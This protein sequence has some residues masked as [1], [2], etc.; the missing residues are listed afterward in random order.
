MPIDFSSLN[1]GFEDYTGGM[2]SD[3]A[4]EPSSIIDYSDPHSILTSKNWI[5]ASPSQRAASAPIA[6]DKFTQAL[7]SDKSR[8]FKLMDDAGNEDERP[9]FDKSGNYTRDGRDYLERAKTAFDV[10]AQLE[11]GGSGYDSYNKSF[12]VNDTIG[13]ILTQKREKQPDMFPG[14]DEAK[15]ETQAVMVEGKAKDFTF[16]DYVNHRNANLPEDSPARL[17][18]DNERMRKMFDQ[19]KELREFDPSKMDQDAF[20]WTA[21]GRKLP[22]IKKAVSDLAGAHAA[23][24]AEDVS[25][26]DKKMMKIG[27]RDAINKMDSGAITDAANAEANEFT[28]YKGGVLAPVL[29]AVGGEV[30]DL[31]GMEGQDLHSKFQRHMVA[32]GDMYSFIEQNQ[33]MF[34]KDQY[35]MLDKLNNAYWAANRSTGAGAML[36]A[37]A[38]FG[39]NDTITQ[40]AADSSAVSDSAFEGMGGTEHYKA[41]GMNFTNKGMYDMAGQV[42]SVFTSFGSG[43]LVKGG[44]KGL[45]LGTAAGATAR[46]A[47]KSVGAVAGGAAGGYLGSELGEAVGGDTGEMVG[48]IVGGVVGGGLGATGV[49]ALKGTGAAT[50]LGRQIQLSDDAI[51]EAATRLAPNTFKNFGIKALKDPS[52]YVGALQAGGMSFGSTYNDVFEQTGDAEKAYHKAGIQGIS[53]GLAAFVSTAVFNRIA[54]GLEKGMSGV[55]GGWS[56]SI[57]K[58]MA[59]NKAARSA[60]SREAQDAAIE[61]IEGLA[62]KDSPLRAALG[63]ALRE[64]VNRAARA[65]GLKGYGMGVGM[66]TEFFEEATDTALSDVFSAMLDD[67]KTWKGEVWDNIQSK[68]SEY[69]SAGVMGA[70]GGGLGGGL[71]SGVDAFS[72]FS[73]KSREARVAEIKQFSEVVWGDIRRNGETDGVERSFI[74]AE[75]GAGMRAMADYMVDESIPVKTRAKVLAQH[76]MSGFSGRSFTEAVTADP[77][78]PTAAQTPSVAPTPTATAATPPVATGGAATPPPVGTLGDVLNSSGVSAPTGKKWRADV[79]MVPTKGATPLK[80]AS[81]VTITPMS[82]PSGEGRSLATYVA[83]KKETIDP[84]TGVVTVEYISADQAHKELSSFTPAHKDKFKTDSMKRNFSTNANDTTY[85][86]E[87]SEKQDGADTG[88]DAEITPPG[89]KAVV[90]DG[91]P[92]GG[93]DSEATSRGA[94]LKAPVAGPVALGQ[95]VEPSGNPEFDAAFSNERVVFDEKSHTYTIDN[96]I[97]P[98]VTTKIEQHP[99][100]EYDGPKGSDASDVGTAIH[101][102]MEKEF[103]GKP[104]TLPENVVKLLNSVKAMAKGKIVSEKVLF[105]KNFAGTVDALIPLGNGEWALLDLKTSTTIKSAENYGTRYTNKKTGVKK[106][107]TAMKHEL[108]MMAYREALAANGINVTKTFILNMPMDAQEQSALHEIGTSPETKELYNEIFGKAEKRDDFSPAKEAPSA[109]PAAEPAPAAVELVVKEKP[110]TGSSIRTYQNSDGTWNAEQNLPVFQQTEANLSFSSTSTTAGHA[111]EQVARDAAKGNRTEHFSRAVKEAE[112]LASKLEERGN[113]RDIEGARN[114]RNQIAQF[115]KGMSAQ[116]DP[117]ATPAAA[118]AESAPAAEE[119]NPEDFGFPKV[120]KG[121]TVINSSNERP[122]YALVE[123]DGKRYYAAM[124]DSVEEK[125]NNL[126]GQTVYHPDSSY[127]NKGTGGEFFLEEITG[128]D[129][130]EIVNQQTEDSDGTRFTESDTIY[131]GTD[132]TGRIGYYSG[133]GIQLEFGEV[134]LIPYKDSP[135]P[136]TT[137][138]NQTDA[139][140]EADAEAERKGLL[141]EGAAEESTPA[142][143]ESDAEVEPYSVEG[144]RNEFE[145]ASGAPPIKANFKE[146]DGIFVSKDPSKTVHITDEAIQEE[147]DKN[148]GDGEKAMEAIEARIIALGGH[149]NAFALDVQEKTTINA[150]STVYQDVVYVADPELIK[151]G[152]DSIGGNWTMDVSETKEVVYSYR[153]PTGS[154]LSLSIGEVVAIEGKPDEFLQ[155]TNVVNGR[156]E[157]AKKTTAEAAGDVIT[158]KGLINQGNKY[159]RSLLAD[160]AKEVQKHFKSIAKGDITPEN[161]EKLFAKVMKVVSPKK[162]F[163]VVKEEMS[164]DSFLYAEPN[165]D[166]T[167]YGTIKVDYAKM[168]V[169]LAKIYKNANTNDA[170]SNT[171]L[172]MDAARVISAWI[173]EELTHLIGFKIFNPEELLSFYTSILNLPKNKDGSDHEFTK[174]LTET[175]AERYP[176]MN[177]KPTLNRKQKGTVGGLVKAERKQL[178]LTV[179]TELIRKLHQMATKGTT[180][181]RDTALSRQL[182][183]AIYGDA[184]DDANET[185]GSLSKSPLRVIGHMIRRYAERVRNILWMKWQTGTLPPQAREMLASM[186]RAYRNEGIQGDVDYGYDEATKEAERR[187]DVYEKAFKKEVGKI[188]R[189]QSKTAMKLRSISRQFGHMNLSQSLVVDHETMTLDLHP[190]IKAHIAEY[191]TLTDE[192][193]EQVEGFLFDLNDKGGKSPAYQQA[194]TVAFMKQQVME[195]RRDS[196]SFNPLDLFDTIRDDNNPDLSPTQR[197]EANAAKRMLLWRTILDGMPTEGVDVKEVMSPLTKERNELWD[198]MDSEKRALLADVLKQVQDI[199]LAAPGSKS[200]RELLAGGRVVRVHSRGRVAS[201]MTRKGKEDGDGESTG[202]VANGD[203]MSYRERSFER[204]PSEKLFSA[205]ADEFSN[206]L[207]QFKNSILQTLVLSAPYVTSG[208]IDDFLNEKSD[209]IAASV[210]RVRDIESRIAQ[211]DEILNAFRNVDTSR[212]DLSS[213]EKA[214][215]SA[216]K[217]DV[218]ISRGLPKK[219]KRHD[220]VFERVENQDPEARANAQAVYT[221]Y[222]EFQQ[223]VDDYN[224]SIQFVKNRSVGEFWKSSEDFGINLA[225]LNV[226]TGEAGSL[227]FKSLSDTLEHAYGSDDVFKGL[228]AGESVYSYGAKAVWLKAGKT[229]TQEQEDWNAGLEIYQQTMESNADFVGK[230]LFLNYWVSSQL[231]KLE[232]GT[233][234]SDYERTG[235]FLFNKEVNDNDQEEFESLDSAFPDFDGEEFGS[236]KHAL[237]KSDKSGSV[238]AL[239]K[240]YQGINSWTAKIKSKYEGPITDTVGGEQSFAGRMTPMLQGL[241]GKLQETRSSLTGETSL[242]MTGGLDSYLQNEMRVVMNDL[243]QHYKTKSKYNVNGVFQMPSGKVDFM[244]FFELE[245]GNLIKISTMKVADINNKLYNTIVSGQGSQF[246]PWGFRNATRG[247]KLLKKSLKAF[248]NDKW[249]R[250]VEYEG[251]RYQRD[252]AFEPDNKAFLKLKE[253]T[254][255]ARVVNRLAWT[256]KYFE[257]DRNYIYGSTWAYEFYD[258]INRSSYGEGRMPYVKMKPGSD[259]QL[260]STDEVINPNDFSG[261]P[262]DP[263]VANSFMNASSPT[264]EG[265]NDTYNEGRASTPRESAERAFGRPAVNRAMSVTSA[266]MFIGSNGP[267][268]RSSADGQQFHFDVMRAERHAGWFNAEQVIAERERR[269]ALNPTGMRSFGG[270]VTDPSTGL[271]VPRI[272]DNDIREMEDRMNEDLAH[273]E[274]FPYDQKAVNRE[275]FNAF[276]GAMTEELVKRGLKGLFPAVGHTNDE[277]HGQIYTAFL[278]EYGNKL[279]ETNGYRFTDS[280]RFIVELLE[281]KM[282]FEREVV[283]AD[284]FKNQD[285]VAVVY[286]AIKNGNPFVSSEESERITAAIKESMVSENF[287]FKDARLGMGHGTGNAIIDHQIDNLHGR[288]IVAHIQSDVANRHGLHSLGIQIFKGKPAD[289]KTKTPAT[290]HVVI[291]P[292]NQNGPYVSKDKARSLISQLLSISAK[293]DPS[294]KKTLLGVAD[295]I[296]SAL[297]PV[298]AVQGMTMSRRSKPGK[299]EFVPAD[300]HLSSARGKLAAT[301]NNPNKNERTI[302][303]ARALTALDEIA[304]IRADFDI[305]SRSLS[306]PDIDPATADAIITISAFLTDDKAKTFLDESF[307]TREDKLETTLPVQI[308]DDLMKAIWSIRQSKLDDPG[309]FGDET[310]NSTY[311]VEEEPVDSEEDEMDEENAST[312]SP[313][314]MIEI[315]DATERND[316]LSGLFDNTELDEFQREMN[317]IGEEENKARTVMSQADFSQNDRSDNLLYNALSSIVLAGKQFNGVESDAFLDE[318]RTRADGKGRSTNEILRDQGK[319]VYT[320]KNNK[321]LQMLSSPVIKTNSKEDKST[322]PAK[323]LT[324]MQ[325]VARIYVGSA[326]TLTMPNANGRTR[327]TSGFYG[328]RIKRINAGLLYNTGSVEAMVE[329]QMT[330][331][332]KNALLA[333]AAEN[334]THNQ[335]NDSMADMKFGHQEL[336]V[337]VNDQLIADLKVALPRNAME[338]AE[339]EA[340]ALV[341][342]HEDNKARF[343]DVLAGL[344]TTR[345]EAVVLNAENVRKY[346]AGTE[347]ALPDKNGKRNGKKLSVDVMSNAMSKENAE[348]AKAESVV[349]AGKL[350]VLD[351]QIARVEKDLR[352]VKL[353]LSKIE[354]YTGGNYIGQSFFKGEIG[355]GRVTKGDVLVSD[356]VEPASRT[357]GFHLFLMPEFTESE[358]ADGTTTV[359]S[360]KARWTNLSSDEAMADA[361]IKA[362][363]K[364]HYIKETA[365]INALTNLSKDHIDDNYK[366][367]RNTQ[368]NFQNF[369][370]LKVI[371]QAIKMTEVEEVV[372]RDNMGQA[373]TDAEQAM[374]RGLEAEHVAMLVDPASDEFVVMTME[375]QKE[376]VFVGKNKDDKE[377]LED[378]EAREERNKKKKEKMK[379][380]VVLTPRQYT[381]LTILNMPKS[382]KER[383]EKIGSLFSQEGQDVIMVATTARE[384]LMRSFPS[385]VTKRNSNTVLGHIAAQALALSK[386]GLP[387]ADVLRF[388]KLTAGVTLENVEAW[389]AE[390]PAEYAELKAMRERVL[391]DEGYDQKG[392]RAGVYRHGIPLMP[393]TTGGLG[394]AYYAILGGNLKEIREFAGPVTGPIRSDKTLEARA[395]EIALNLGNKPLFVNHPTEVLAWAKK[396]GLISAF[397]AWLDYQYSVNFAYDTIYKGRNMTDWNAGSRRID[398]NP[399]SLEARR[400]GRLILKTAESKK[401]YRDARILDGYTEAQIKNL[402]LDRDTVETSDVGK[403]NSFLYQEG[404]VTAIVV[405]WGKAAK[406][407]RA[408]GDGRMFTEVAVADPNQIKSIEPFGFEANGKLVTPD[409]WGD[410]MSHSIAHALAQPADDHSYFMNSMDG[411]KGDAFQSDEFSLTK[412]KTLTKEQA[413]K[414]FSNEFTRKMQVFLDGIRNDMK[415]DGTKKVDMSRRVS[416]AAL[417]GAI[418]KIEGIVMAYN[419][420]A[421]VLSDD[422]K[423]AVKAFLESISENDGRS[424]TNIAAAKQWGA[425]WD[426]DNMIAFK[427]EE[428]FSKVF[429]EVETDLILQRLTTSMTIHNSKTSLFFMEYFHHHD[430]R[431][432]NRFQKTRAGRQAAIHLR[433]LLDRGI[434]G[435]SGRH[436][437]ERSKKVAQEEIAQAAKQ[438]GHNAQDQSIGYFIALLDGLDNAHGLTYAKAFNEWIKQAKT[439]FAQYKEFAQAQDD[440][441]GK[442][443]ISRYWNAG[444]LDLIRDRELTEKMR[445]ILTSAKVNATFTDDVEARA[446]VEKIKATLRKNV[447][448]GKE[449]AVDHYAKTIGDVLGDI[450]SAMHFTQ[451]MLSKPES[452][453]DFATSSKWRDKKLNAYKTTYSSVPMSIAYAGNPAG[454]EDIRQGEYVSDPMDIVSFDEASFFGGI[455]HSSRL[456]DDKSVFRPISVNGLS[457]PQSL[458][459]DAIYRLNVT[460]TYEV[461]RRSIGKVKDVSGQLNIEDSGM[462]AILEAQKPD[463]SLPKHELREAEAEH[464]KNVVAATTAL[465]FVANELEVAIRNDFQTGSVN[466]GGSETLRFLSSAFIVRSLASVQQITDQSVGPSIGYTLG[467]LAVGKPGMVKNYFRLVAKYLTDSKFREQARQLVMDNDVMVYYRSLDGREVL[468]DVTRGQK[469]YGSKMVKNAL[470]K[471]IRTYEKVGEDALDVT[472]GKMERALATSVFIAELMDHTG[473]I[474]ENE[475]FKG[476]VSLQDMDIVN[477]RIKVNE[478]F[479]QS[480]QSN[481]AW[482]F[483][484][485]DHSPFVSA[486]W[487]ALTLFSNHTSSTASNMSVQFP[488]AINP[489]LHKMFKNIEVIDEATHKEALENVVATFVQNA[490]FPI[491]KW[492][493]AVAIVSWVIARVFM[494]DDED[495][496]VIHAQEMAN[497]ILSPSED[498]N[499][500]ANFLK[501]IAVGKERELFRSDLEPDAAFA[502]AIAE[503]FNKILLESTTMLPGGVAA[504]YSPVSGGIERFVTNDAAES[505]VTMVTNGYRGITGN[506]EML[507]KSRFYFDDDGVMARQYEAGAFENVMGGTAATSAVYDMSAAMKLLAEYNM[508]D[509]AASNRMSSLNKSAMYAL[510]EIAPFLRDAR[511]HMKGVLKDVVREED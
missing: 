61:T 411:I 86:D 227:E 5:N 301:R 204:L 18:K 381:R 229:L 207:Q 175:L 347:S 203:G 119:S 280:E 375:D 230:N 26:A 89:K 461:L 413:A 14:Y 24:D 60:V 225:D 459:D 362:R 252:P 370:P 228:M 29:N 10:A 481:K 485:R 92:E 90:V 155:V 73:K 54:P 213:E 262:D 62:A 473:V 352:A 329:E 37:A 305:V 494:G 419:D 509:D 65:N 49:G 464:G 484:S 108:Q 408:S 337:V 433:T 194:M 437:Y 39:G 453:D 446:E 378:K 256:L 474:D 471:M 367:A 111:T 197:K 278:S 404:H 47:A 261:S 13:G 410:T 117:S 164:G 199:D 116:S 386:S 298:A 105:T 44:V 9:V 156:W 185:Q 6:F 169:Q 442:N 149:V 346:W 470:G 393:N 22:N 351:R 219:H 363:R 423:K 220:N 409:Q 369:N 307:K 188:A 134:G 447:S 510:T 234:A 345:D 166:S 72:S 77:V 184:F 187:R 302:R 97:L 3:T 80:I 503:I 93:S 110:L 332:I 165:V 310:D 57:F 380:K 161:M 114:L 195:M 127:R 162:T 326:L 360:D 147:L 466:T 56:G 239:L 51:K 55:E 189:I 244:D 139:Q 70:F 468:R 42:L 232:I 198:E 173:D 285:D 303:Y 406:T 501:I 212:F 222:M 71:H 492:K 454:K 132:Y 66:A 400:A 317:E 324:R 177:L 19:Q 258:S 327:L 309:R 387:S 350:R 349:L 251:N 274:D 304:S 172:G 30:K 50:G 476:N 36:L 430:A 151:G 206:A 233:S 180:T 401:E 415:A 284:R 107:S 182:Q 371:R 160:V 130:L 28:W 81:N 23:I 191:K 74:R 269:E 448:S 391:R 463:P 389:K 88:P 150:A 112:R 300:R 221:E 374:M 462:L 101:A 181:E 358:N 511:G 277:M 271:D 397:H 460:P 436:G 123:H 205:N 17:D 174:I 223:S 356:A 253:M 341:K 403:L 196:L 483:Q 264:V 217:E 402:E 106:G 427:T 270:M 323:E 235:G 67:S 489:L 95:R 52:A 31:V 202:S 455:G 426:V 129:K 91:G 414:T 83:A 100:F 122:G 236:A 186:N 4:P 200:I 211:V 508:T 76:A 43:A 59:F 102:E 15:E 353:E 135:K 255:D 465:A 450:D 121:H 148:D 428:I 283:E 314:A 335:P 214:L 231:G 242:E 128:D 488:Q 306:F 395:E 98:S 68:F 45:T 316:E 330:L 441:Y 152:D 78:T 385:R 286:E 366:I 425:G 287:W 178:I 99:A 279:S 154:S 477:S 33:E 422:T 405:D 445:S 266:A 259:G 118:V 131:K 216:K 407:G 171:L 263:R 328:T 133:A 388:N 394:S 272:S 276:N 8:T 27:L 210:K 141:T 32:E 342:S 372:L 87:W 504:G 364:E 247:V 297:N 475:L 103:N 126:N 435:K 257:E 140:R 480:D 273:N 420:S 392:H 396:N 382:M 58:H 496:A 444:H 218:R 137:N 120:P 124:P 282:K 163:K 35:G 246:L 429:M 12:S 267:N 243:K 339:R 208:P 416:Q 293:N 192:E 491:L 361:E 333:K 193:M 290:P 176:G 482:M 311:E 11:D 167:E 296:E 321:E 334:K 322:G 157:F 2:E 451:A 104:S 344:K 338:I 268:G 113:E 431:M 145:A 209:K 299:Q 84:K 487:K 493:V 69:M 348:L 143:P 138:E 320:D 440:Y 384:Q 499:A 507:E 7:E 159:T 288:T 343:E 500:I 179:S 82:V 226:P 443:D 438:V 289:K 20:I 319:R 490:L 458:V 109:T 377:S 498:G 281:F 294:V 254:S 158:D 238:L 170:A 41:L 16:D 457:A 241:F 237:S 25:A 399:D 38:P 325:K 275:L 260:R 417:A 418:H 495:E 224:D 354:N 365:I 472:I 245:N 439:G 142:A 96:E 183:D 376:E 308:Q 94:A 359:G 146:D 34:S 383:S 63:S 40:Y 79:A 1:T 456:F 452:A 390:N 21:G 144:I 424:F 421:G 291:L 449:A 336:D 467:K 340:R 373:R 315:D 215:L 502:S 201:W 136:K 240:A 85:H 125:F 479:G 313:D 432:K 486:L 190:R 368:D 331:S 75:S 434:D 357:I 292:L 379:G 168:A 318:L 355:V 469:R 53:D 478:M 64:S 398:A 312:S 46:V 115:E 497:N 48:G 248:Q 249:H 506:N 412:G 153:P 505:I 265:Y 250:N 295:K